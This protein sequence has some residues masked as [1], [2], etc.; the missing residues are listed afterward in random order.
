MI[1]LIL[2]IS[3]VAL[4]LFYEK[5]KSDLRKTFQERL[6]REGSFTEEDVQKRIKAHEEETALRLMKKFQ[7]NQ[8]DKEQEIWEKVRRTSAEMHHAALMN[9]SKELHSTFELEKKMLV[10]KFNVELSQKLEDSR[11][12]TRAVNFGNHAQHTLTPLLG[13]DKLK[14]SPKDIRWF[15]DTV[16]YICFKGLNDDNDEVEIIFVDSKTGT[17]VD[18]IIQNKHKWNDFKS[19]NPAN[20]FL[21]KRQL[22]I[23]SAIKKG[24]FSFQI[25]MADEKGNFDI[26]VYDSLNG[27]VI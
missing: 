12:Q 22:K 1:Y 2:I 16:D 27:S 25:W 4:A 17:D 11:R 3:I 8:T 6:E 24:N 26:A 9:Q 21:N 20:K 10:E 15:G 18:N 23:L 13:A 19:Y 5:Q 7:Q 14:M